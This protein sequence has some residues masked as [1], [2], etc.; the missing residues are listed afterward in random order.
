[1]ATTATELERLVVRLVGEGSD[2]KK[3]LDD[4]VRQT[5]GASRQIERVTEGAMGKHNRAMAEAASITAAATLPTERYAQ[6]LKSLKRHY[7][8]GSITSEVYRRS[9]NALNKEFN[10]GRYAAQAFGRRLQSVGQRMQ[11]TGMMLTFGTTLA[12]AGMV[13]SYASF[14]DAMTKSTAIMKDVTAEVRAEMDK[15]A[16]QISGQ[17]VT[18]AVDLAKS[19]F[20]LASAGM[21]A[22]QSI[23]ALPVVE[24]FAVAGAFDMSTATDLL[25]DAQSALGYSF[26]DS[27]KNMEGMLY[28]SDI[29]VK[30]NTLANASVHQ[31][32]EALTHEA[33]P[34]IKQYGMDLE[35]G[36]AILATYADQGIKGAHAG[37]MLGRM[38]RLLVKS[39]NENRKEFERM[40]IPIE[41]F[42]KTGKDL[43]SVLEGI[44]KATAGMGPAE[45]A[46]TL[47]L[48]GFEARIQQAILPLLGL[49]DRTRDYE[50]KLRAAGGTTKEVGDKHLKSF[51]AQIKITWNQIRNAGDEIGKALIPT[52]V[53][54]TGF[55]RSAITYWRNLNAGMKN[56]I[57]MATGAAAMAGPLLLLFGT[58]VAS[59]GAVVKALGVLGAT[60][61]LIIG[62]AVAAAAAVWLIVDAW[63]EAD[64]GIHKFLN[65]VTIHGFSIGNIMNVIASF[66]LV[67]WK[68]CAHQI[69]LAW[70]SLK[71]G[72]TYL[73][74]AIYRTALRLAKGVVDIFFWAISLTLDRVQEMVAVVKRAMDWAGLAT[75]STAQVVNA[76]ITVRT[77]IGD[78]G[79]NAGAYFEKEIGKSLDKSENRW[80]RY[81]DTVAKLSKEYL[82][83][84]GIYLMTGLRAHGQLINDAV[85]GNKPKP[86]E[87]KIPEIKIP[88]FPEI[89]LPELDKITVPDGTIE[90]PKVPDMTMAHVFRQVDFKQVA[91]NRI[92]L[93]GLT[94]FAQPKQQEVRARGV[95]DRLDQLIELRENERPSLAMTN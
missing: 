59:I 16:R 69:L 92:N 79:R 13:A 82:G 64:L 9:V 74:G 40:N 12:V 11:M 5:K 17:S 71:M 4:A 28:V 88:E 78:A 54:L 85:G 42:A 33:G 23:A 25:T 56:F 90:I 26:T 48:L 2:Y 86:P 49:T 91:M 36:V 7:A 63:T 75:K 20:Y 32:S 37:S 93:A 53:H 8:A 57:I 95:E 80:K 77:A 35:E 51:S 1:M 38:A 41:K 34:A 22:A 83:A 19:Y 46:A 50:A 15:T 58:L 61:L 52:L 39:I 62:V 94:G 55:I 3:V 89:K 60:G 27:K 47:E 43:T 14:D 6:Q 81:K 10:R 30:A 66:I 72:V 18:S 67:A 29:L 73:M 70:E 84:A 45:K 24:K 68:L 87:I 65:S 31:F 21:S 44:T 76:M